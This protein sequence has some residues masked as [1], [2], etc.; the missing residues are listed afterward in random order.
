MGG[1][2]HFL[3]ARRGAPLRAA[4]REGQVHG[5]RH[6]ARIY[7]NSAWRAWRRGHYRRALALLERAGGRGSVLFGVV[8]GTVGGIER[9]EPVAVLAGWGILSR[10]TARVTDLAL[11]CGQVL[12]EVGPFAAFGAPDD[13]ACARAS[14]AAERRRGAHG[15]GGAWTRATHPH[16][17]RGRCCAGLGVFTPPRGAARRPSRPRGAPHPD[18]FP[19]WFPSGPDRSRFVRPRASRIH[20]LVRSLCL[21]A[22]TPFPPQKAGGREPSVRQGAD[23]TWTHCWNEGWHKDAMAPACGP[24]GSGRRPGRRKP[25]PPRAPRLSFPQG[26]PPHPGVWRAMPPPPHAPPRRPPRLPASA[27]R[28]RTGA[29]RRRIPGPARRPGPESG[30]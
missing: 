11:H 14:A 3:P 24:P 17:V 6:I 29:A 15:P 8:G 5:A 26:L 9:R 2:D 20:R 27:G 1:A 21:K 13:A 22:A 7:T 23:G 19:P 16:P 18:T 25:R 10:A 4:R 28:G 12:D 30:G